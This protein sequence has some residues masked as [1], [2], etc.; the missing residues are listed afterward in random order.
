MSS[1][2]G[3]ITETKHKVI[4]SA[5][6]AN[7]AAISAAYSTEKAADDATKEAT[8]FTKKS[9]EILQTF[10]NDLVEKINFCRSV[11]FNP[12]NKKLLFNIW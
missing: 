12:Q 1:L 4:N 8:L 10:R 3:V 6:Y 11:F 9:T 5:Y 2:E 7:Q